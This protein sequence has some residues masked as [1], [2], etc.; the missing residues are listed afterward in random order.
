MLSGF[1]LSRD[2]IAL[3][4]AELVLDITVGAMDLRRCSN[5][6]EKGR[7]WGVEDSSGVREISSG[8][9]TECLAVGGDWG[10]ERSGVRE[11]SSGSPTGYLVEGRGWGVEVCSGVRESSSGSPTG[12]LVEGWGRGVEGC[13]GVREPA[14]DSESGYSAVGKGNPGRSESLVWLDAG[15][16]IVDAASSSTLD[17]SPNRLGDLLLSG[18]WRSLSK[19]NMSGFSL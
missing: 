5:V 19:V 8:S 6:L 9:W 2:T 12:Y 15:W 7:D 16:L 4:S 14:S 18:P 11:F 1:E 13:S 10:V 17:R 3:I